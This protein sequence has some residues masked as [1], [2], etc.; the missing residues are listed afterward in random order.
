MSESTGRGF[1]CYPSEKQAKERL[2][3][4][5]AFKHMNNKASAY[6][7]VFSNFAKAAFDG[8]SDRPQKLD[9]NDLTKD[10]F[11][12]SI[13]GLESKLVIDQKDHFPVNT[14][15]QA[16]SSMARAMQLQ[17]VP[18]WYIGNI[19]NL[20][21]DVYRG[22]K[23]KHPNLKL[24]VPVPLEEAL[25]TMS[26]G[27]TAPETKVSDVKN[28]ADVAENKTKTKRPALGQE[29]VDFLNDPNV[30]LTLAQSL[31]E[32]VKTLQDNL[33]LTK[34]VCDQLCEEGLT[35]EQFNALPSFLQEDILRQL[36]LPGPS[37]ASSDRRNELL[38]KLQK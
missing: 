3:E 6:D 27:E 1:G 15:P 33:K 37:Y 23:A 18:A 30:R 28:P 25:G 5:E 4:I 21:N 9:L 7:Q 12:G 8:P 32:K 36:T 34:K 29:I 10:C 2:A 38:K 14:E 35:A 24:N 16:R 20:K 22:V 26:D 13:A 31:Q 11:G 19:K 17:E